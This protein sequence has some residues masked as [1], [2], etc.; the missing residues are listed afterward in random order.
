M[1]IQRKDLFQRF[2]LRLHTVWAVHGL[3]K[4]KKWRS[5]RLKQLRY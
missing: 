1:K 2:R 4:H 5:E 3:L